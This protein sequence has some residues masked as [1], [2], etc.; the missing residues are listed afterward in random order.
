MNVLSIFFPV[1]DSRV[2]A[3]RRICSSILVF[4]FGHGIFLFSRSLYR[5]VPLDPAPTATD[6]REPS[7][8][9]G[10]SNAFGLVP[11]ARNF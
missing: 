5:W 6:F 3:I 10:L 9:T 11:W 4:L 8:W 1:L 2:Q 7:V